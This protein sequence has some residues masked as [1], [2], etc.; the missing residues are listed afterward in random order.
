MRRRRPGD[1]GCA[2]SP[3][4]AWP[5][6][7]SGARLHLGRGTE[8]R[9]RQPGARRVHARRHHHHRRRH[10]CRLHAA[11]AVRRRRR[12]ARRAV[13]VAARRSPYDPADR[14]AVD[15]RPVGNPRIRFIAPPPGATTE[16]AQG[17]TT[18]GGT[19]AATLKTD[20]LPVKLPLR[21]R[22]DRRPTASRPRRGTRRPPAPPQVVTQPLGNLVA[23]TTIHYR[24]VATDAA[25]VATPTAPTSPSPS[26]PPARASGRRPR[27][28]RA[29]SS[30]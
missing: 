7:A 10:R 22:A 26:S 6:I 17:L 19:M 8:Q 21:V 4:T 13:Q 25:G 1:G 27:R 9:W 18:T 24:V 16:A 12:P 14:S 15:Q 23:G 28:S 3:R 5:S 2:R 20:G 29:P 30:R 11:V